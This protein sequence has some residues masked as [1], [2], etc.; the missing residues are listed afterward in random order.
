MLK[1]FILVAITNVYYGQTVSFQEFNSLEQ[2][3]KNADYLKTIE[4]IKQAYCTSK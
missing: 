1:V 3:Q 2:C 4:S